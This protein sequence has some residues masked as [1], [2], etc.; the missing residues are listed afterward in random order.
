[1]QYQELQAEL[2]RLH[3]YES[4]WNQY[5][6]RSV[7]SLQDE[8]EMRKNEAASLT[9]TIKDAAKEELDWVEARSSLDLLRDLL[10]LTILLRVFSWQV[11]L[12]SNH[13]RKKSKCTST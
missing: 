1:M 13:L 11:E 12:M 4:Q 9:E 10:M 5:K 8:L 6:Q 3:E 7:E 2:A